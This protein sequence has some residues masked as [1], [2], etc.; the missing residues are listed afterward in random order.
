MFYFFT[1]LRKIDEKNLAELKDKYQKM[2]KIKLIGR[3]L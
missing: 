3:K 2:K 1:V